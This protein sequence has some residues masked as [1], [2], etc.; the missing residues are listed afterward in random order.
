MLKHQSEKIP[1]SHTHI[2]RPLRSARKWAKASKKNKIGWARWKRQ[3]LYYSDV[4]FYSIMR[5]TAQ[6]IL[7]TFGLNFFIFSMSFGCFHR[8]TAIDVLILLAVTGSGCKLK[9]GRQ[10]PT[11]IFRVPLIHSCSY[12]YLCFCSLFC[13]NLTHTHFHSFTALT[14]FTRIH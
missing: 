9:T 5:I 3:R 13:S 2:L 7:C 12:V 11:N 10:N 6:I 8:L 4:A 14:P 1:M